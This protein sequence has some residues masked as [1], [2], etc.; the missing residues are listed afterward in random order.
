MENNRSKIEV[1]HTSILIHDYELHDSEVLEKYLSVYDPIRHQLKLRGADWDPETKILYIPRGV[2]INFLEKTFN[3][4]AEMNY[5]HDP[6]ENMSIKAKVAPRDD[7]QRNAIAF[8]IGAEKY[9]YT[10]KYS[11]LLLNLPTG[12]G[13]TYVMT[14]ALQFIN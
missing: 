2:D 6:I 13:K 11:Q 1:R 4:R 8:L 3:V 10:K 9:Q 7:I 14:T 5:E 12:S